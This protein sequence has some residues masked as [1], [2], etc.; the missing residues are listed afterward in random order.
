MKKKLHKHSHA[1]LLGIGITAILA[2]TLQAQDPFTEV[3]L[4][5]PGVGYSD[6]ALGDY[7]NDGDL[8]V[9]LSGR[10]TGGGFNN[11][12]RIY[13]ND[14]KS[15]FSEFNF[16]DI[17]ASLP[18]VAGSAVAWGDYDNDGDLDVLLAGFST[19]SS[20]RIAR[21]YQNDGE[22]KFNDLNAGLTGVVDGSVDWG[23]YDGDGDLDILLAGISDAGQVTKV[24]RNEDAGLHFTDISAGLRGIRSGI[25]VWGDYDNDSDLDIA[26]AGKPGIAAVYR[27]EGNDRF[28][29]IEAPLLAVKGGSVAWGD[30]DQDGDL[31]LLLGGWDSS[32]LQDVVQL[33]ENQGDGAFADSGAEMSGISPVGLAWGDYDN[34]GAL[35][36]LMSGYDGSQSPATWILHNTSVDGVAAFVNI[37]AGLER[38]GGCGIIP[39]VV[40]GDLDNDGDLDALVAGFTRCDT[41]ETALH[42]YQ[43]ESEANTP[44]STP[45]ALMASVEGGIV[46]LEWAAASDPDTDKP[47][48]LT[49]NLRIGT[50]PGAVDILAPGFGTGN[51]GHGLSA[52]RTLPNPETGTYYWSVQAIDSGQTASDFA[53]EHT[54][55]FSNSSAAPKALTGVASQISGQTA[56]LIAAVNAHRLQTTVYFEWGISTGYGNRTA[57]VTLEAEEGNRP[58]TQD[59][60]DLTP[61]TVYH[62]RVVASNAEGVTHGINRNFR[63]TTFRRTESFPGVSSSGQAWGDYDNDGD[64]DFVY[65]GSD[66]SS[67]KIAALYRNEGDGEFALVDMGFPGGSGASVAWGDYDNDGD[68]DL[69]IAG[70][71][72]SGTVDRIAHLYRNDMNISGR[73]EKTAVELLGTSSGSVDWGDYDNDGDLDLVITGHTTEGIPSTNVYRNEG[74]DQFDTAKTNLPDLT[75][76]STARWGDFDGDGDLDLL[77]TGGADEPPNRIVSNTAVSKVF[78]YDGRSIFGNETFVDIEAGLTPLTN[79]AGAWGDYDADG[80]LD[81]LVT[82]YSNNV[83]WV[84]SLYHNNQGIFE[85][86]PGTSFQGGIWSDVIWGD[87]DNDGDLDILATGFTSLDASD[88]VTRV[89]ENQG[90]TFTDMV[91]A[92]SGYAGASIAWGDADGDG[93]LDVLLAGTEWRN[94][95]SAKFELYLNDTQGSNDSPIAPSELIATSEEGPNETHQATL[96]WTAALGSNNTYNVRIGTSPGASDIL[97]GMMS[98]DGTRLLPSPGNAGSSTKLTLNDLTD[99]TYYWSVQ[100]V[101]GAY[102]GSVLAGEQSFTVGGPTAEPTPAH[103]NRVT[104]DADGA[105]NLW[106]QGETG[107]TDYQVEHSLDLKTW[108]AVAEVPTEDDPGLFSISAPNAVD[109]PNGYYRVAR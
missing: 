107:A 38:V 45:S 66:T 31:D 54:I 92:G 14:G 15:L 91:I 85:R 59:I 104:R 48:G 90:G 74:N 33:Y 9:L 71:R 52:Q 86:V 2:A 13:R 18:G 5:L 57:E 46:T 73:F 78:R 16:T 49:Y 32:I 21:I 20:E 12:T 62:Y 43:N 108:T 1:R 56:E 100:S 101:N 47:E 83:N 84:M 89:Y 23:D 79:G 10:L 30:Y 93:D 44:P 69:L 106:F 76:S 99:G 37:E 70:S 109:H 87:Y 50:T 53:E 68:L 3:D 39:P 63:T 27:N 22:D 95:S 7:D 77:V 98:P 41:D 67:N 103:I 4:D 25:A 55:T 58:V 105:F 102:T 80:D 94:Q 51:A 97:S 36:I 6:I 42:F 65:A 19:S 75:N 8:D 40:W 64:L 88:S 29:D 82:G 17:K 96:S 11:I 81:I 26:L 35:D 61:A 34:D 24:Y 60:S 28:V 72:G